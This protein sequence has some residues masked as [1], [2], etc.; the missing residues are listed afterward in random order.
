MHMPNWQPNWNN[1][2]WNHP[3]ANE[4]ASALRRVADMLEGTAS[5][6]ERS[7]SEAKVEW[8]GVYR[9]EF[10]QELDRILRRARDLAHEYRNAAGNI[11]Q[12]SQRAHDEQAR[13]EH[14]R[15][16]WWAE[17]RAEELAAARKGK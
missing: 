2:V 13:R 1:V 10:D 8:R 3:A 11:M 12:A 4:A 5:E 7:A 9:N 16:R 14:D 17:K 6:R 15:A